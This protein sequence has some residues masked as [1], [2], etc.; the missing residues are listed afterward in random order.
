[1]HEPTNSKIVDPYHWVM[2]MSEEDKNLFK[3][4]EEE[5]YQLN[6]LKHDMLHK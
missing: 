1:M 4:E 2:T 6:L 3:R 5:Y